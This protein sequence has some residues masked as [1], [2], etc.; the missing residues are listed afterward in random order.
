MNLTMQVLSIIITMQIAFA[1][2]RSFRKFG[3]MIFAILCT[4]GRHT[5][6]S[7]IFFGNKENDDWTKF[8]AKE[9]GSRI[10][11]LINSLK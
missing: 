3:Y 8:L 9:N 10:L 5:I 2:V 1:Q 4:A 7:F 11:V 6:T